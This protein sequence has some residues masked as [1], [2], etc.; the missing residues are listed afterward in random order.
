MSKNRP[1][2]HISL[3]LLLFLMGIGK[4]SYAQ[5][6]RSFDEEKIG[7]YQKEGAYQYGLE[8]GP[9]ERPKESQTPQKTANVNAGEMGKWIMYAIIG[10]AFI[11]IAVLLIRQFSNSARSNSKLIT[12]AVPLA[13]DIEDIYSLNFGQKI[14]DAEKNKDF[15]LAVRYQFLRALRKLDESQLIKW[16]KNKTDREY[17]LELSDPD[18]R[19]HF[20]R[21]TTVFEHVW[22]GGFQANEQNYRKMQT[23][24]QQF[25]N[26][27]K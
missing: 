21:I 2:C 26:K 8:P 12:D 15:R 1:I 5:M 18:I 3:F 11:L 19:E 20:G 22:Y 17:A 25:I 24:F 23:Y 27:V 16:Q 14:I 4:N 10:V 13:E 7:T 9:K 6:E